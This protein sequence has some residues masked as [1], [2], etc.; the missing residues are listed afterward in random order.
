MDVTTAVSPPHCFK[1]RDMITEKM[2]RD[3]NWFAGVE[4]SM[5]V[6]VYVWVGVFALIRCGDRTAFYWK[7]LTYILNDAFARYICC[8]WVNGSEPSPH[9][10]YAHAVRELSNCMSQRVGLYRP[11]DMSRLLMADENI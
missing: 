2:R 1:I 3:D 8:D 4:A 10:L 11:V 6:C 5:Y 7:R 9:Y